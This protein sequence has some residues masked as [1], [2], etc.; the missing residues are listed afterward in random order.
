[1]GDNQIQLRLVNGEGHD[2]D[3]YMKKNEPIG[4]L[5]EVVA[6]WTGIPIDNL[7]LIYHGNEVE[8]VTPFSLNFEEDDMICICKKPTKVS[9]KINVLNELM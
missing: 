3:V 2:I 6:R 1:M 9:D 8:K 7:T 5:K 4:V